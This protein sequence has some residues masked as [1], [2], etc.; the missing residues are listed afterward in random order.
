MKSRHTLLVILML[1]IG[2]AATSLAEEAPLPETC[3]IFTHF[4]WTGESGMHLAWSR[5]GLEWE[6]LNDGEGV[7]L[8]MIGESRLMRDPSV[9][10][11]GDGR[12]HMV[13]TTSW[14]GQT[15]G[16][17]SSDDLVNWGPQQL[18]PVMEHEPLAQNCWAPEIHYIPDEELYLILWSTT[19]L[20]EFPE[21]ALSNRRFTRNHR[22]YC[23]TT[24]DFESFTPTELYYDGGYNVIDAALIQEPSGEW[25]MFVKNETYSPQ[26]EKN[27]RLIRARTWRGPFSAPSESISGNYW[28][29]GP[30]PIYIDG[31]L[32]VFFDKHDV[33][34]YGVVKTTDTETWE[35]LSNRTRFP[36]HVRHGTFLAVPGTFM[37]DLLNKHP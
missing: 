2:G 8:P 4:Y 7:I 28:A 12:F 30:S 6:L 3:Y 33:G 20:G 37:K 31:E 18:I 34:R 19:L 36:E 10:R 35:D 1:I 24:T 5:D 25:L 22:I 17:A 15:I 27:I 16:Y 11:G 32:H 21:T 26:V 29:E 13:W 14:S 23:T 9:V